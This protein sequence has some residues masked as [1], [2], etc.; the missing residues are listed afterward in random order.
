[1]E[2]LNG[3]ELSDK[4]LKVFRA[5]IGFTQAAGLDMGINAMSM[6]AQSS[7]DTERGRVLLLLNMVTTDELLDNDDYEG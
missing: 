7:H 2:G 6:M 5:S 3:M 4:K 1:M